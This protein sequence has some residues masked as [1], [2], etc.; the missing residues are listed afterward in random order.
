M[1]NKGLGI[2][3]V[4]SGFIGLTLFAVI[5]SKM[6][7]YAL[8]GFANISALSATLPF[9]SF[10]AANGIMALALGIGIVIAVLAALG[11]MKGR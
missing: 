10:F 4:I 2:G 7:P 9:A 5:M 6:V 8:A 3:A 11:I 1:F